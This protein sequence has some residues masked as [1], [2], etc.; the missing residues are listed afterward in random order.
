MAN[1]NN[2]IHSKSNL[3]IF[4]EIK[5]IYKPGTAFGNKKLIDLLNSIRCPDKD[6]FFE[7]VASVEK[8]RILNVRWECV[9]C[10]KWNI[11]QLDYD[12]MKE[13]DIIERACVCDKAHK[14]T[15]AL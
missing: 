1:V 5:K 15:I 13:N 11:E 14:L 6:G 7:T 9:D 10:G 12:D 8:V 3:E 2:T 4:H